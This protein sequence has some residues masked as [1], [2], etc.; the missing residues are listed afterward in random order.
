MKPE[1]GPPRRARKVETT[2]SVFALCLAGLI[3]ALIP[4]RLPAQDPDSRAA[5]SQEQ[6]NPPPTSK[7]LTA[8]DRADI[9]MVRKDY[10]DAVD[11][12]RRSLKEGGDQQAPLWNKLGIA[13]QHLMDFNSARKA[14]KKAIRYQKDFPEPWNNLGTTY[15]LEGKPKKSIK[16]YERAVSLG[17]ANASFHLNLGTAYFRRKKIEKAVEEYRT[18]LTLDP[19]ILFSHSKLG[20]IVEARSADAKYYFYLAKVFASLGRNEEAIRNLRRAFEEGF[21]DRKR[22][23]E[24]P[25]I[26]KLSADPAYQ[27]LLKNPPV[28]IK[29]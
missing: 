3:L 28:A 26:Q 18:A 20:T 17:P 24:D 22:L 23:N 6:S 21:D 27:E 25:D 15:F 9:F 7:E 10:A 13:Y 8:Q 14:Y 5:P 1:V 19:N 12:Y 4:Q 29:E 11:Y 2:G 16:F